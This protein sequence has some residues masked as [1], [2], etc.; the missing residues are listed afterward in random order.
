MTPTAHQAT[1]V[2]K[3]CIRVEKNIQNQIYL[4]VDHSMPTA[5]SLVRILFCVCGKERKEHSKLI[6][7]E[8][9]IIRRRQHIDRQSCTTICVWK[10]VIDSHV[11]ILF[12]ACGKER[13]EHSK[14]FILKAGSFDAN[15][16][17]IDSPV[18]LFV[19]AKE[20][21]KLIYTRK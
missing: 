5:H 12:C 19:C 13:K 15:S 21:S 8:S 10:V 14:L 4:K 2:Y 3:S 18:R 20:H 6:I 17:P 1:V 9:R 7:P 11:R 16:K